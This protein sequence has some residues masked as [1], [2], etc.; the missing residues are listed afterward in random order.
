M[1][2]INLIP[3]AEVQEQ[4]K[5]KAVKLSTVVTIAILVLMVIASGITFYRVISLKKEIKSVDYDLTSL[6]KEISGLAP[7][8]IS[9]RNLDKKFTTIRDF[10]ANR[11][12]YSL[13]S[14]EIK[15]R[16]PDGVF[17]DSMTLQKG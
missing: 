11:N 16:T 3:E 8:E 9:A 12:I 4:T 5:E 2:S 14:A 15:V 7:V 6:R 10:F 17:L 1:Q 13:L